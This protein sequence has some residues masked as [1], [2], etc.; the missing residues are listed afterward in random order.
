MPYRSLSGTPVPA[1]RRKLLTG[2]GTGSRAPAFAPA[3]G[4][5]P[6]R[7]LQESRAT[8]IADSHRAN[9]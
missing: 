4:D 8:G 7:L 3:A 2:P 9:A 1:C 5:A 6:G